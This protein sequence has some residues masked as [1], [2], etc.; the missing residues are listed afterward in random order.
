MR[1]TKLKPAAAVPTVICFTKQ[2]RNAAPRHKM[3]TRLRGVP[4]WAINKTLTRRTSAALQITLRGE[5][6]A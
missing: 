4:A 2:A 3:G 5:M 6:Q 1:I